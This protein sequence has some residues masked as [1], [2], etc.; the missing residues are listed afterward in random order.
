V[1][2]KARQLAEPKLL[3]NT[4]DEHEVRSTHEYFTDFH[5]GSCDHLPCWV[6]DLLPPDEAFEISG[7]LD[8][9]CIVELDATSS[10]GADGVNVGMLKSLSDRHACCGKLAQQTSPREVG[11]RPGLAPCNCYP[12]PK[13]PGTAGP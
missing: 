4:D 12:A 5:N 13:G 11:L 6:S 8:A 10:T 1:G 2:K 9:T 7:A 3:P